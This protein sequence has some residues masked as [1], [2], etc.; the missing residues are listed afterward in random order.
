MSAL[1]VFLWI[2]KLGPAI[3]RVHHASIASMHGTVL[4]GEQTTSVFPTNCADTT[5]LHCVQVLELRS[6]IVKPV[7]FCAISMDG[8]SYFINCAV[9]SG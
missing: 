4:V 8:I 7:G 1:A 9:H 3:S 6:E 5:V 2:A